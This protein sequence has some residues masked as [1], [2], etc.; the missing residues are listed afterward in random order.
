MNARFGQGSDP[1]LLDDVRCRGNEAVLF[2]CTHAG[3]G[4][5]NCEHSEDASVIVCRGSIYIVFNRSSLYV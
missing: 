4:N 3:V 1:I 2:E 5:H